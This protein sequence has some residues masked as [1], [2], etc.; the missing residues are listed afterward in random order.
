MTGSMA[1]RRLMT[2]AQLAAAAKLRRVDAAVILRHGTTGLTMLRSVL[3]EKCEIGEIAK[4][5]AN[6]GAKDRKWWGSLLH[7][8]LDELARALG[9][10][11]NP[12]P[13]PALVIDR[14]PAGIARGRSPPHH[15]QHGLRR[16]AIFRQRPQEWRR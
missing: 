8:V 10:A 16:C 4:A 15:H 12:A 13:V 6:G 14:W 11:S 9:V 7:R 5:H 2:D 3:I 1:A